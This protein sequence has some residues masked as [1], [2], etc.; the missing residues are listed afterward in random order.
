MEKLIHNRYSEDI[1]AEALRRFAI[2]KDELKP[3]GGFES[4]IYEYSSNGTQAILRVSHSSRY[5]RLAMLGELDFLS[6]LRQHGANIA[7]PLPS[8]NGSL[9]EA[10]DDGYGEQFLVSSFEKAAGGRHQGEWTD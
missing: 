6:Y 1:Q 7:A 5:G 3:L 9:L 2:E 10:I 8:P 4:F